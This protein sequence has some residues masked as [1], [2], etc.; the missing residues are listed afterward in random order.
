MTEAV[1]RVSRRHRL[2]VA[3]VPRTRYMSGIGYDNVYSGGIC[4]ESG[5][6]KKMDYN[7]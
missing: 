7:T 4:Y 1:N 2:F 6:Q 5:L 3:S